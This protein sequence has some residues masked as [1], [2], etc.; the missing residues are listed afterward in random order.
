MSRPT[1]AARDLDPFDLPEWL[2]AEPVI[3]YASSRRLSCAASMSFGSA[4]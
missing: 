4:G 1:G 3:W 2:G